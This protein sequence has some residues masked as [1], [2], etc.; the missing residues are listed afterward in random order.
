[1]D[2]A[3]ALRAALQTK[4]LPAK[5]YV[6]MRYWHPFTE[7][8]IS[9]VL[10]KTQLCLSDRPYALVMMTAIDN[11]RSVSVGQLLGYLSF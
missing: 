3:E 2:Q 6:G 5:V 10:L 1:M 11:T 4:D 7:E 9:Q 8:A